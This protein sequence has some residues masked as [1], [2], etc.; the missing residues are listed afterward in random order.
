MATFVLVCIGWLFF[1]ETE[2]SQLWRDLRLSPFSASPQ[3]RAQG[4]YLFLLTSIYAAPLWLHDVWAETTATTTEQESSSVSWG[5]VGLQAAACG[6]MAIGLLML[7]SEGALNF[8]YF[9]F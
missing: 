2:L 6:L 7:Q 4:M 5:R 1:R 3:D 9:A 8:I